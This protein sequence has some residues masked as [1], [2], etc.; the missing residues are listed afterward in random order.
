MRETIRQAACMLPHRNVFGQ[1]GM[2]VPIAAK[3]IVAGTPHF[4]D[5]VAFAFSPVVS[6]P[7]HS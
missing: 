5:T 3:F 6:V 7:G 2:I 4:R 1:A